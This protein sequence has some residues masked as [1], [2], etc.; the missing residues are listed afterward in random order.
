MRIHSAA[1]PLAAQEGFGRTTRLSA[2]QLSLQ[3]PINIQE[4]DNGASIGERCYRDSD[5]RKTAN[6]IS[7]QRKHESTEQRTQVGDALDIVLI[8]TF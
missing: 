2:P 3:P 6:H 5:K 8:N 7:M 4:L 1:Q